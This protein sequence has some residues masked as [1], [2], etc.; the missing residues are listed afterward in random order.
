MRVHRL[1]FHAI[2]VVA[3][4]G[5]ACG[6]RSIG[7]DGGRTGAAGSDASDSASGSAGSGGSGVPTGV[8]GGGGLAN[9]PAR[10]CATSGDCVRGAEY[11]KK[12][13]CD[14]AQGT[15]ELMPAYASCPQKV[16]VAQP[17]GGLECTPGIPWVCGC[18]HHT[19]TSCQAAAMGINV[20]SEGECPPLPSG[21]CS[22]QDDC[23][24]ASF[25]N[26]VF[27]KVFPCGSKS[28]ICTSREH[29]C[30]TFAMPVCGCDGK[31]YYCPEFSNNQGVSVAY[32]GRCDNGPSAPCDETHPCAW[33]TC[34]DDP[35]SACPASG[36][37]PGVCLP[38]IIGRAGCAPSQSVDGGT[39]IMSCY[40]G[41]CAIPRAN[42]CDGGECF[43]C[44][45]GGLIRCDDGTACP[46]DQ[47]CIAS[48]G[49]GTAKCPSYCVHL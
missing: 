40:G 25:A 32:R 23:G 39:P 12:A 22:S 49:C 24:G 42:V 46:A 7:A 35:R 48:A 13:A 18:D 28:G 5:S 27:C 33:G 38:T 14:D 11:C 10:T 6:S 21:P 17:D 8:G 36:G 26:L 16:C 45:N 9:L 41:F 3:L 1:G 29:G 2:V 19:A 34:F 20:A 44:V 37:C 31:D 47:V 43:V 4:A 15:C 30:P